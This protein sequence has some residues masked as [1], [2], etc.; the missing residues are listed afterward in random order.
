[1]INIKFLILSFKNIIV[2]TIRP[3]LASDASSILAIYAPFIL[4]TAVSF[5]TEVPSKENFSQRILTTLETYPWLVYES[6][7]TIAGYAYASRHRERAAYQWSVESSVYVNNEFQ[8]RGI[9]SKLYKALFELLKY[10]GCRNVYAGITLPNEKSVHFHQKTGFQ[11]ISDYTKIGYKL[12]RW[13][14]VSWYHLPLNNYND[15][16]STFI[17]LK[18]VASEDVERIINKAG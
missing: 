12:N 18:H 9:A 8:Q 16:P 6:D 13:N 5:E 10:Q 14:T 11:K 2:N 4:N 17:K 7:G 1:M 3:A 15:A